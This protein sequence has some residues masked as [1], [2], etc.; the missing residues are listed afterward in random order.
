MRE[1][2]CGNLPLTLASLV[3]VVAGMKAAA[4]LLVPFLLAVFVAI[5]STPLLF[6]LERR[7]LS[8][9]LAT[10]GVVLGLLLLALILSLVLGSSMQDFARDLPGYQQRLQEYVAGLVAALADFGIAVPGGEWM[11][12]L[13]PGAAIG[14]VGDVFRG[15]G[16]L[17][18]NAFLIFLTVTFILAEASTLPE[19]M[20]AALRDPEATLASFTGFMENVHRYLAI[21]TAT[22]AA[23]GLLVWLWLWIIGV[24]YPVLWGLLAF[25]LNYVPNIG[26]IIAAVPAVLLALVQAGPGVAGLAAIGYLVINTGIGS[27]VEPRFMGRGLGLSSLVVFLSLVFWGWVLGTVGMFLSVPLTMLVK[28][29][30]DSREETRWIAVLLGARERPRPALRP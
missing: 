1:S 21:K 20:R 18:A 11:N 29:A 13:N 27:V 14:L 15:L 10:A 22:S 4:P 12:Y 26:S 25:M 3:I 24:D 17:L 2:P 5:I 8:P 23:T 19:K 6:W 30:L 16:G 7:G 28:I 9:T